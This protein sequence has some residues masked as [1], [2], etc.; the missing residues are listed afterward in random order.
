MKKAEINIVGGGPVGL[1]L[2]INLIKSGIDCTI[3]EKRS[4]PVS[5]SRSLGI[6]PVSMELFRKLEIHEPFLD[7]GIKIKKGLAH[8]GNQSLGEID[9][10][11]LSPPFNFILAIPQFQTERI[12]EK[13]FLKLKPDGLIRNAEVTRIQQKD[14]GVL[15]EYDKDNERSISSSDY[16]IACDGKNSFVR[17]SQSIF[18]GGKRYPDTYIMGD[19]EDNTSF[20]DQAVV[21][22]PKEGMIE[23]FP[24]PNGMRR[25]V[26]KTDEYRS[27]PSA[28][29]ISEFINKRTTYNLDGLG[30]IMLS[31]FGVQH[32][33]AEQFVKNKIILCGDAAHVVS[34]IGGQGM[35]LGWMGANIITDI[36]RASDSNEVHESLKSRYEQGHRKVVQKA[37]RRAECNMRL[38][39]KTNFP[40]LRNMLI[41]LLLTNALNSFTA[42]QF[43]MKGLAES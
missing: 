11:V 39:R 8:T 27:N 14:D 38:G 36:F 19:F 43:A 5:D 18:F 30:S 9:F 15:L 4:E 37:A 22:L 29:L 33:M 7:Q 6:H 25:W 41:R 23:C 20:G 34:P 31:A 40:A 21:F 1:F 17:Q 10:S 35:N 12:L 16:L 3:F 2:G 24:L 42:K 13:A 32:F 26:V 28:E